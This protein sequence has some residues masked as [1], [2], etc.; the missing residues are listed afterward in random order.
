MSKSSAANPINVQIGEQCVVELGGGR[1][2][3]GLGVGTFVGK[4]IDGAYEST[5]ANLY[6]AFR[7]LLIKFRRFSRALLFE[8]SQ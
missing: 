8:I 7:E 6:P 4:R 1:V 3:V 5:V 2:G